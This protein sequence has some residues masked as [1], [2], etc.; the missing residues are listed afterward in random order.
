VFGRKLKKAITVPTKEKHPDVAALYRE[1][2][3]LLTKRLGARLKN[4]RGKK[5]YV[6][7][8]KFQAVLKERQAAVGHLASGWAAAAGA[9]DVPL[10]AWIARHGRGRGSVKLDLM[11]SR[12]RITVANLPSSGLPAIVAAEL[13]RRIGYAVAYQGAAMKREVQIYGLKKARELGIKTRNFDA[14]VPEG[15]SGRSD[16]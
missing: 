14:L 16:T 1:Q 6:D 4:F 11:S 13:Q 5:F 15:M 10:Q 8:R 3:H 7:V 12:M 9:L 2:S